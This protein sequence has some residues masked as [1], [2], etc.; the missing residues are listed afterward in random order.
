VVLSSVC[1]PLQRMASAD[2]LGVRIVALELEEQPMSEKQAAEILATLE[3]IRALL[4]IIASN[5][6]KPGTFIAN[7]NTP[8]SSR[9]GAVGP[10]Q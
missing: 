2:V 1:F 8:T 6:A 7:A 3:G 10:A 9:T 5:T 4:L